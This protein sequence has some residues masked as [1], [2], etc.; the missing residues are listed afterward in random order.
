MLT[1]PARIRWPSRWPRAESP[2]HTVAASPYRTSFASRIASR[3]VGE[4]GERDDR[5]EDLLLGDLPAVLDAA[6]DGRLHEGRRVEAVAELAVDLPAGQELSALAEAAADEAAHLRRVLAADERSDLG[7]RRRADRRCAAP[8]PWWRTHRRRR[9]TRMPPPGSASGPR[10]TARPS[11]R[12]PTA[13]RAPRRRGRRRR[14]R[15]S[16]SCRRARARRA[17]ASPPPPMAIRRPV[18]VS[19][20]NAT[21]S[22]PGGERSPRRPRRRGR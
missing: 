2:V 13:S 22:I 21:L 5:T 11:S 7:G 6:D 14:R 8:P 12:S 9:R 20:V 10:T 19:P 16:G 18:V 4:S 15:G 3:L 17:S 1:A